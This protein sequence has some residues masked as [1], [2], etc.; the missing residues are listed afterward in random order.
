MTGPVRMVA[1]AV[2]LTVSF[3]AAAPALEVPADLPSRSE[4]LWVIDQTRIG[5][6]ADDDT[7]FETRKTWNIC[8]DAGAD[9]ALH[10]F[11]F[12]QQQAKAA[13]LG[14]TCEVKQSS[15]SGN[16]FT[17]TMDCT[18]PTENEEKVGKFGIRYTT[19]FGSSEETQAETVL[20]GPDKSGEH[21]GD[22]VSHM[23]RIGVCDGG[24]KPG[25]MILMHWRVNGEETLKARQRGNIHDEIEKQKLFTASWLSR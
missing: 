19:T 20:V 6:G 22:F 24:L 7:A 13:R 5:M 2:A 3:C 11:E 17:W 25:D 23:K 12:R 8:L 21:S 16:V 18:G 15:L 9:R 14:A 10:E 4:G 1:T